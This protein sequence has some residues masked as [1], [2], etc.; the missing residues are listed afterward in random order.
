MNIGTVLRLQIEGTR[1]RLSCELIGVDDGEYL[2]V[3]MPPLHTMANVSKLLVNENEINAKYMNK[4]TMFGFQS[5]IIDLIHKPFKLVFIKYPDKI[6][7]YDVRGNKRVECFLPASVKIAEQI[8]KGSITDISRAGCL[9]TI[10]T[11]ENE[12]LTNLLELNSE[13]KMGFYLPGIAEELIAD[14]D[15]KS[16]KIDTDGSSI[17]IEFVG[18]DSAV[19][20]K[21]IDFLSKAG[22]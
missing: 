10:D 6:D 13:I 22:A 18:M 21:L 20:E 1:R 9:F 17:G 5:T 11:D 2:I 16:I 15:Q 7:S 14:A 12:S 4:G 3:K 19:K 8:L